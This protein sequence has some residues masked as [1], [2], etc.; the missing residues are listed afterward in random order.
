M[1]FVKNIINKKTK[2][3]VFPVF[4]GNFKCFKLINLIIKINLTV[5]CIKLLISDYLYSP[6]TSRIKK[7]KCC[8]KLLIGDYTLL[9]KY[10]QLRKDSQSN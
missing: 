7:I 4:S 5:R 3:Y 10:R 1:C 8:I 6:I 2:K 9:P